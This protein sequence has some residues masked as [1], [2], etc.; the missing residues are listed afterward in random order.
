MSASDWGITLYSQVLHPDAGVVHR[1][2]VFDAA[3]HQAS[4]AVDAAGDVDHK[5]VMRFLR[6]TCLAPDSGLLYRYEGLAECLTAADRVD[7]SDVQLRIGGAYTVRCSQTL[8]RGARNLA[9]GRRNPGEWIGSPVSCNLDAADFAG[10]F[11]QVPI[12]QAERLAACGVHPQARLVLVF[13]QAAGCSACRTGC[14][15]RL[16]RSAGRTSPGLGWG[17]SSHSG[18]GSNYPLLQRLESRSRSFRWACS[19]VNLGFVAFRAVRHTR[20]V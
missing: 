1:Y 12:L 4:P 20:A 13:V 11:D 17:G 10:H 3:C 7:I 8:W 16:Y 5:C 2:I 6:H 9:S 14:A 18:T 15:G 19:I